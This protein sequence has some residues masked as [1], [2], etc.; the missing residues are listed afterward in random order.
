MRV[1]KALSWLS[2][3]S[4]TAPNR[5]ARRAS[6][7]ASGGLLSSPIWRSVA[8]D[9][10]RFGLV[11]AGLYCLTNPQVVTSTLGG[12]LGRRPAAVDAWSKLTAIQPVREWTAK[13]VFRASLGNRLEG[14]D[15]RNAWVGQ[16]CWLAASAAITPIWSALDRRQ[17]GYAAAQPWLHL[18]I[19]MCLAGQMFYYGTAKAIPLQF[20]TPLA[21]LVE[22]LG[23]FSPMDLLW[24][25]TGYSK[26][27]Q[28]LLGSAEIAAGLLLIQPKTATLGAVLSAAEMSQ[29]LLL[30]M[31]FDVPVK[32]H[33]LHLLLLS[34]VLLAPES[35][36]LARSLLSGDTAALPPRADLFSSVRANQISTAAQVVAGLAL[37]V[38]Q[39][40]TA[41][42]FW[43]QFGGGSEKP[44][45]YGIWEVDDFTIDGKHRPPLTT[46]KQRWQ[47]VIV[48]I[49]GLV[50]VQRM[51]D[52]LD[53]YLGAANI[54]GGSLTLQSMSDPGRAVA[55][56]LQCPADDQLMLEGEV[57]GELL[58]LRLHRLD[59]GEFPLLSRGFH[60]VQESSSLR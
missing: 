24:A 32:L 9:A 28:V 7:R 6:P 17:T 11:Y 42:K 39:L 55:M 15:N 4:S 34:G 54:P 44:Q 60:W 38:I 30:N 8:R 59:H 35:A 18:A 16:F 50:S 45:L 53:G 12:G 20:Q 13:H 33:T 48:D 22:P 31:A 43:R 3:V 57:E 27:Y 52:S 23:N 49:G 36:R 1:P 56:R 25:Q 37:L 29:V 21:R 5:A 41:H 58:R 14:I 2:A 46:D 40:R 47:R 10:S 26:P 51:D 19:R